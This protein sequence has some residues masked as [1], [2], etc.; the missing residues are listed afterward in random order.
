MSPVDNDSLVTDYLDDWY[1]NIRND[2]I[3]TDD[4]FPLF[5][6]DRINL[7]PLPDDRISV[8]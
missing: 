3:H 4:I 8:I 5:Q 2:S 1:L 6:E 7:Y